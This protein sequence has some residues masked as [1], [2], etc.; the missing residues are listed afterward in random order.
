M[1]QHDASIVPRQPLT[2]G[3]TEG[4]CRP[5]F[6][7]TPPSDPPRTFVISQSV[8]ARDRLPKFV[9]MAVRVS[10]AGGSRRGNRASLHVRQ[11]SVHSVH[12]AD[13]T[14]SSEAASQRPYGA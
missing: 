13:G 9:M 8:S 6:S 2:R 4:T 7:N 11:T 1:G 14:K 12:G 3:V 5:A 10:G